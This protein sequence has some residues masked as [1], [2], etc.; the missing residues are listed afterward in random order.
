MSL[1]ASLKNEWQKKINSSPE[2]KQAKRSLE[3]HKRKMKQLQEELTSAEVWEKELEERLKK[4]E[5]KAQPVM[6]K[7]CNQ[8]ENEDFVDDI[9][10]DEAIAENHWERVK[11]VMK[12]K[13]ARVEELERS[14]LVGLVKTVLTMRNCL[15]ERDNQEGVE[16]MQEMAR[17]IL[18]Q[19]GRSTIDWIG[20]REWEV[21]SVRMVMKEVEGVPVFVT[22]IVDQLLGRLEDE[23]SV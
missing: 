8:L 6:M 7:F 20:M 11:I 10:I 16:V 22:R 18:K 9:I 5:E 17:T 23:Q 19:M 21:R 1:G 12:K 4:L 14:K 15:V 2:V 3:F 13:I